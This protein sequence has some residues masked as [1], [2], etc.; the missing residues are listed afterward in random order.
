MD[1]IPDMS[2]KE[3]RWLNLFD[4]KIVNNWLDAIHECAYDQFNFVYR[5]K[6]SYPSVFLCVLSR[7]KGQFV[8]T[9]FDK[10]LKIHVS[11]F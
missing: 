1:M 10:I 11:A 2:Y 7:I 8:A 4:T 9:F 5:I 3:S 6:L